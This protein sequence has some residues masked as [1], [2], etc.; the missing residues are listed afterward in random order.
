MGLSLVSGPLRLLDGDFPDPGFMRAVAE[1][2]LR[3]ALELAGRED[4]AAGT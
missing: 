4:L 2:N 1:H 3:K